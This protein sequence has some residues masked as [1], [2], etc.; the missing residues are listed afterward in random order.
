MNPY[1]HPNSP[2]YYM[3]HSPNLPPN[4]MS[5]SSYLNSP[6]Y[7]SNPHLNSP[8]SQINPLA[9]QS[10][11]R[12]Y[13]MYPPQRNYSP[14]NPD[15]FARPRMYCSCKLEFLDAGAFQKHLKASHSDDPSSSPS[16]SLPSTSH[17]VNKNQ[18]TRK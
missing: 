11:P 12:N 15:F 9:N 2:R 8:Q 17:Q 16:S 14:R 10:S 7:Y 4:Q 3:L 18:P 13:Y 5:P 6:R 1:S